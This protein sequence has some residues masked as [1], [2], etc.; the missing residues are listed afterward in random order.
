M[1]IIITE[2]SAHGRQPIRARW[3]EAPLAAIKRLREDGVPV[4]GYTWFPLFTMI[5]W[6]YRF[7][8][9]P[10]EEYRIELGLYTLDEGRAGSRWRATPLVE[11]FRACIGSPAETVGQLRAESS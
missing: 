11:Q 9:G 10:K 1:P 6:K 2:T 5:D 8:R 7:G 4:L 3:L